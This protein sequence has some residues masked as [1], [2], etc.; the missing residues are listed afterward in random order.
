MKTIELPM[1]NDVC[2]TRLPEGSI[3]R[4]VSIAPN[5]FL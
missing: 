1:L 4:L 5:A 2:Q 3:E